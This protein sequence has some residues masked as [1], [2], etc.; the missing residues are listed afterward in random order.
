MFSKI[1]SAALIATL[2]TTIFSSCSVDDSSNTSSNGPNGVWTQY[3]GNHERTGFSPSSAPNKMPV[4]IT[5]DSFSFGSGA[6][7]GPDGSPIIVDGIL[8]MSFI[9]WQ[10]YTDLGAFDLESGENIWYYSLE[11]SIMP[12]AESKGI[13]Y[14]AS[15]DEVIALD[16][17]KGSEIWKT[18]IPWEI[19][20]QGVGSSSVTIY[21][22]LVLI[23]N[24]A[25]DARTGELMWYY[26][27]SLKA[28]SSSVHSTTWSYG[29]TAA[30]GLVYYSGRERFADYS[31]NEYIYAVDVNTGEEVWR[32]KVQNRE[33]SRT[34]IIAFSDNKLYFTTNENHNH[35][36]YALNA[37]TGEIVWKI[38]AEG[39][40]SNRILFSSGLW[41]GIYKFLPWIVCCRPRYWS[42]IMAFWRVWY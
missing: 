26:D 32:Q 2:L 23:S 36:R 21:N 9:D 27:S 37:S 7:V 16:A 30:N 22:E 33:W 24:V 11:S 39:R 41:N 28:N 18:T 25:L 42:R 20:N 8:Y 19:S 38:K 34:S 1:K 15:D 35:Y 13:L 29:P 12:P 5:E 10:G 3:R 14:F 31:Q 6:G 40:T 17:K 4:D